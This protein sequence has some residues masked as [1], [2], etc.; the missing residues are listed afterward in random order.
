[1][2][3]D[4]ELSVSPFPTGFG[5]RNCFEALIPGPVQN[6]QSAMAGQDGYGFNHV[7]IFDEAL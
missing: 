5:Y 6:I 3:D 1:M 7:N 4:R 2:V